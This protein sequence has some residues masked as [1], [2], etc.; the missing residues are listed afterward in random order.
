[1][2]WNLCP[3]TFLQLEGLHV[4][5]TAISTEYCNLSVISSERIHIEIYWKKGKTCIQLWV[6]EWCQI[7]N[8][9]WPEKGGGAVSKWF[10]AYQ[11][12]ITVYTQ[13]EESLLTG[14]IMVHMQVLQFPRCVGQLLASKNHVSKA[15]FCKISEK[16][17]TL[18]NKATSRKDHL[19][20]ETSY[21]KVFFVWHDKLYLLTKSISLQR[22]LSVVVSVE[23]LHWIPELTYIVYSACQL[24][25]E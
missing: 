5:G 6:I 20:A 14:S 18:V 25:N 2:R 22:P 1:M 23:R 16:N 4:N 11:R 17:V 12:E 7:S 19:G 9:G 21:Q 13:I 3:S 8:N 10:W 15:F 24:K